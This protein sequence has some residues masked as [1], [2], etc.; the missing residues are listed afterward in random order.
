MEAL[1]AAI[2]ECIVILGRKIFAAADRKLDRVLHGQCEEA[3]FA[4]LEALLFGE[5]VVDMRR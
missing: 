3:D 2:A 5:G 4:A 1:D